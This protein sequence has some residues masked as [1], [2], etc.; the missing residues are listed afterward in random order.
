MRSTNGLVEAR[1]D[2][3]VDGE[4]LGRLEVALSSLVII[5]NEVSTAGSREAGD[6]RLT[7]SALSEAK[8][9]EVAC[10]SLGII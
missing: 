3:A 1:R 8:A 4:R 7:E 10:S 6:R 5:A 2:R 9:I